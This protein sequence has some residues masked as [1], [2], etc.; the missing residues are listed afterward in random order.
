MIF[1]IWSVFLS[2]SLFFTFFLNWDSYFSLNKKV[3]YATE[4]VPHSMRD[5]SILLHT[6]RYSFGRKNILYLVN[7]VIYYYSF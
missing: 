2:L 1:F 6:L 4:N 5:S 7:Y 3:T